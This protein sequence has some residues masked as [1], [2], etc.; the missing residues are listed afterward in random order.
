MQPRFTL[1]KTERLH[2]RSLIRKLFAFNQSFFLYPFKVIFIESDNSSPHFSSRYPAQVLFTVSKKRFQ[3]AVER[4]RLKRFMREGYRK[5]KHDLY[6]AL[7]AKEKYLSLGFIYTG[8]LVL[9]YQEIEKKIKA[10]ILRLNQE[11]DHIEK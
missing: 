4:N 10:A 11:L 2:N 7:N 6:E 8:K 5:N 9:P 1:K 3:S